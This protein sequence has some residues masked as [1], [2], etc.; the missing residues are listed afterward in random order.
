MSHNMSQNNPCR[1]KNDSPSIFAWLRSACLLH[2]ARFKIK[3][4]SISAAAAE[5]NEFI[6]H[7]QLDATGSWLSRPLVL[8]GPAVVRQNTYRSSLGIS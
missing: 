5:H 2:I 4:S 6:R 3:F 1:R 7:A 8:V